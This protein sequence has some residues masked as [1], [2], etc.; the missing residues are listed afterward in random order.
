LILELEARL[1]E[2]RTTTAR[3][4]LR[5]KYHTMIDASFR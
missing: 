1:A 4:L 2:G 5:K 3:A